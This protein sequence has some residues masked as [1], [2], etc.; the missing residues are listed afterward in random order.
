[1]PCSN[2]RSIDRN[3][4]RTNS[5]TPQCSSQKITTDELDRWMAGEV[6]ADD[7]PNSQTR[8][9]NRK[10]NLL[11]LCSM[12]DRLQP[13][14][15]TRGGYILFR[16]QLSIACSKAN[17]RGGRAWRP[18]RLMCRCISRCQ[19]TL[20]YRRYHIY[21][22]QER[23]LSRRTFRVKMSE[24]NEVLHGCTRDDLSGGV[25][26]TSLISRTSSAGEHLASK[27]ENVLTGGDRSVKE[28]SDEK[29]CRLTDRCSVP[30]SRSNEG[31]TY[32]DDR[33]RREGK[34]R[35]ETLFVCY[36]STMVVFLQH[37]LQWMLYNRTAAK[38]TRCSKGTR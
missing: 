26:R 20:Y 13:F 14:N 29:R 23:C 33:K 11:L 7:A 21:P 5:V 8:K 37:K 22:R 28:V 9:N 3:C 35:E 18:I 4:A 27:V 6:I 25:N 10:R 24:H 2:D 34:R 16:R 1:M 36:A 17:K 31:S 38:R 12:S 30:C 15:E 32:E 19:F